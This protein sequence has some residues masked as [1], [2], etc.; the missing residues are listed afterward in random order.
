MA[1]FGKLKNMDLNLFEKHFIALKSPLLIIKGPKGI[2][3]CGYLNVEAFNRGGEAG[4][5][6]TGVRTHEDMLNAKVIARSNAAQFLGVEVGMTG[7][8]A[9]QKFS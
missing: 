9:L 3:G 2:L 8:E 5:I 4:A 7:E 1:N 6:V